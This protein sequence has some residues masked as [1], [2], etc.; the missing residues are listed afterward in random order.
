M[1]VIVDKIDEGSLV[2]ICVQVHGALY[3]ANAGAAFSVSTRSGR[4]CPA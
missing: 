2:F 4:R 1:S 3:L